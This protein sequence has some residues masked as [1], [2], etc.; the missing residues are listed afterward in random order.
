MITLFTY[1]FIVTSLIF[2]VLKFMLSRS[3]LS[4]APPPSQSPSP[5]PSRSPPLCTCIHHYRQLNLCILVNLTRK[6]C[7]TPLREVA[8]KPSVQELVFQALA[9]WCIFF[10][11]TTADFSNVAQH[12]LNER[13]VCC[14]DSAQNNRS[15]S[16]D[17]VNVFVICSVR[18]PHIT[19]AERSVAEKDVLI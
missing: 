5:C 3:H 18:R 19:A 4:L 6:S 16:T 1:I 7:E 2:F 9:R 12:R 10:V 13:L 11:D 17:H 14:E 8:L 15:N